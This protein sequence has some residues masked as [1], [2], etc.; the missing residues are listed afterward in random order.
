MALETYAELVTEVESWVNRTDL[1]V[2]TY[3][4][5]VEADIEKLN[6]IRQETQI[7]ISSIAGQLEL[8]TDFIAAKQ[9]IYHASSRD[10]AMGLA[11]KATVLAEL[12]G[13]RTIP[14][15]FCRQGD[16]LTLNAACDDEEFT[17]YYFTRTSPLEDESTNWI[18]TLY[19]Q[20]YLFGCITYA[21]LFAQNEEKAVVWEAKYKAALLDM[22]SIEC[23]SQY[24]G[25]DLNIEPNPYMEGI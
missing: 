25:G 3:V 18:L 11:S 8:P 2:S 24:S 10:Q 6:L 22:E 1:T 14:T 13:T 9:L 19:P 12:G 5:M 23:A 20:V 21:W 17:L 7:D 16:Y 4:R 15:R